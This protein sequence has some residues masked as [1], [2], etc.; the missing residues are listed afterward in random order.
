MAAK[1]KRSYAATQTL[2]A[3]SEI[4]KTVGKVADRVR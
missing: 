3:Y 2:C 1:G 4:L